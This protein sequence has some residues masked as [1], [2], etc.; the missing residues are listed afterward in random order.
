MW[1]EKGQ[2]I[3]SSRYV[4]NQKLQIW[5]ANDNI[6]TTLHRHKNDCKLQMWLA[7]QLLIQWFILTKGFT[8]IFKETLKMK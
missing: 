5:L 8:R 7:I 3:K 2:S 6:N 1:N 4:Q